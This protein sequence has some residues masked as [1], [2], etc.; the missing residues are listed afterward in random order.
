MKRRDDYDYYK[1]YDNRWNFYE[2]TG[3][4]ARPKKQQGWSSINNVDIGMAHVHLNSMRSKIN[5]VSLEIEHVYNVQ[6]SVNERGSDHN[7]AEIAY[8]TESEYIDLLDTISTMS[9][10]ELNNFIASM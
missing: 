1:D 10:D 7:V 8:L 9:R 4:S 2:G 5:L 6:L 3:D